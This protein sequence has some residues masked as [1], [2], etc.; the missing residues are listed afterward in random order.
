M[1][2]V[3]VYILKS[4]ACLAVFVV[5]YKVLLSRET[6]HRFNRCM[7]LGVAVLS[8]VLPLVQIHLD[9][10]D[11]AVPSFFVAEEWWL[12]QD[13][14]PEYGTQEAAFP[15]AGFVV[16]LYFAGMLATFF[17]HVASAFRMFRLL[18]GAKRE[19]LSDGSVLVLHRRE[20]PPF[21][22]MKFVVMS[23]KDWRENGKVILLHEEAHVR[24][25]HSY[26]LLFA[27]LL[28]CVQWFNPAVW[29]L[30]RELQA[31]HEYE[32]DEAAVCGGAD[33]KEYQLLLIKKAVGARLYSLANSFNHSSLKKRITMMIKRKSNPWARMKCVYVLPLAAV[34]VAAFA[35]PE[36]SDPLGE[37][38]NAKVTDL[39]AFVKA[40]E[41]KSVENGPAAQPKDS[42]KGRMLILKSKKGSL[43]DN[44]VVVVGYASAD[45]SKAEKIFDEVDMVPE[46]PGGMKECFRFLAMNLRYPVKA[47]ENHIEGNV[48]VRFVVEKDG[49]LSGMHVLQGADPYLDAEALRVIGSM[50]KWNPGRVDGKPVRTRFVLPIVFKLQEQEEK[51]DVDKVAGTDEKPVEQDLSKALILVDGEKYTGDPGKLDQN[52]IESISIFRKGAKGIEEYGDEGKNGV[53][54]IKTKKA[55]KLNTSESKVEHNVQEKNAVLRIA[56]SDENKR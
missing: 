28:A 5:F 41:V 32:A 12:A 9:N 43:K 6:F 38:S 48:A 55:G 40:D 21:S 23:E 49:S 19:Q 18:D 34:A 7:L 33:A 36:V 29:W 37:I 52:Q 56:T 16:L 25:Y 10:G 35:R 11:A 44:E 46:Y 22:W 13:V 4:S 45:E 24:L 27:G 14:L 53:L 8:C 3:L 54:L 17:W 42:L 1:G 15:W 47:I 39:S 51:A 2:E 31:V 26:D 30:R 50:P 20:A